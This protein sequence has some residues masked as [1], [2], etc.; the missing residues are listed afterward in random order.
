MFIP[1]DIHKIILFSN[2]TIILFSNITIMR[3]VIKYKNLSE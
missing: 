3:Y 2:I 1:Y